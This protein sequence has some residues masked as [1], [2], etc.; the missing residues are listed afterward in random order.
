MRT[1]SPDTSA[2][3]ERIQIELLRKLGPSGRLALALRLSQAAVALTRRTI[4]RNEPDL[5][6]DERAV[7]F[8]ELCYGPELAEGLRRVLEARAAV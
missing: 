6:E 4:A 1:Q 7:R 3:A 5:S 8:V 2:D